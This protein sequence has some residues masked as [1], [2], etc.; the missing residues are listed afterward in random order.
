MAT[1]ITIAAAVAVAILLPIHLLLWWSESRHT[2]IRRLRSYGWPQARIAAAC[3]CSR[4]TVARS[5]SRS[6]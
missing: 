2:R 3:G 6:R 4:S 5:L 1:T